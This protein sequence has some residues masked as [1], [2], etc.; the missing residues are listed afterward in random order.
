MLRGV[1]RKQRRADI[2]AARASGTAAAWQMKSIDKRLA[3]PF[4]FIDEGVLRSL[5]QLFAQPDKWMPHQL[6]NETGLNGDQAAQILIALGGF[7]FV[8]LVILI[9]HDCSET[10]LGAIPY[11]QE[12]PAD[13]WTCPEC[14]R[15]VAR[16]DLMFDLMADI[17]QAVRIK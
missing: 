16:S 12:L 17:R 9:Y 7:D 15:S 2:L 4:A 5:N 1:G 8:S 11:G 6:A 14:E 13:S 10:A 3:L